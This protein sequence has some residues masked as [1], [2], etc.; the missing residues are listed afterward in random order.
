MQAEKQ[1]QRARD[2]N[3]A[4][5]GIDHLAAAM[6]LENLMS[7]LRKQSHVLAVHSS[8][9]LA[10]TLLLLWQ[11]KLSGL[12]P[13][14]WLLGF[15]LHLSV[16]L[17]LLVLGSICRRFNSGVIALQGDW[18]AVQ[19]IAFVQRMDWLRAKIAAR[20]V[21]DLCVCA[22]LAA[23]L[24]VNYG[25]GVFIFGASLSLIT[26]ILLP[27]WQTVRQRKN[28]RHATLGQHD[29]LKIGKIQAANLSSNAAPF[30]AW[31]T[32]AIPRLSRL[33]WWWLIPFLSLPMGSHVMLIAALF[34]GFLA[35]TRF[36]AVCNALST[37]LAE[38][39]KL[40][41]TTPLRPALLYRA[42]LI[43]S[44]QG[45]FILALM[46]IS[47]VLSPAQASIA[48][49]LAAV[50]LLLL[51]TA[52]HFGFGYRLEPK[53]SAARNR[54]SLLIALVLGLIA[55]SMPVLLPVVC[56]LL[57]FWLYQRGAHDHTHLDTH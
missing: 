35:L 7:R 11:V 4:F 19:P 57:W 20:T 42:A 36:V 37:A 12:A 49:L 51:A 39:S 2:G 10:I 23:L 13:A 44:S 24:G 41:H 8:L 28:A 30:N 16:A 46:A 52:L 31:F 17:V 27:Y 34:A 53:N 55:N 1:V 3:Q 45:A 54:A 9:F 47:L 38:I 50:G 25:L 29:S 48:V 32:S 18:L 43:F 40:T 21:L 5:T 14:K 56:A 15:E 22:A 26:L 6:R 33:R